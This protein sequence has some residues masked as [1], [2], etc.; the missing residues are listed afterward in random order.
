MIL[1][2]LYT[3]NRSSSRFF[4]NPAK[5]SFAFRFLPA[6]AVSVLAPWPSQGALESVVPQYLL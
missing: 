2:A 6:V 3:V 5:T 1:Q 4:F